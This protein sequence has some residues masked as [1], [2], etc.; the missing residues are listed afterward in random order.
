MFSL[1][2][3]FSHFFHNSLSRH[4]FPCNKHDIYHSS[5][6]NEQTIK[7]QKGMKKGH[8]IKT[9]V[10]LYSPSP[11][12]DIF[13]VVPVADIH[14]LIFSSALRFFFRQTGNRQRQGNQP[15]P[16]DSFV[17]ACDRSRKNNCRKKMSIL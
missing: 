11:V 7:H 2:L 10:S 8:A 14:T 17:A 15:T 13:S 1:Y 12:C 6:I 5:E 3:T 16:R 9:L 4:S